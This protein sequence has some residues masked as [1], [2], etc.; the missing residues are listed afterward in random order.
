MER[1]TPLIKFGEWMPD[2]GSLNN[3]GATVAKNVVA[4]G[5]DYTA[6]ESLVSASDALPAEC[7]GMISGFDPTG[8]PFVFAG[9]A[10]KLYKLNGSAWTDVTRTSGGNYTTSGQNV[11]RFVQYGKYVFATNYNDAMQS[12]DL[13]SSTNFAAAAGSPPKAKYL[14][15]INNFV[16]ALNLDDSG[17]FPNRVEWSGLDDPTTWVSSITT[18]SDNQD[19]ADG[20]AAIALVG[21]QNSGILLMERAIYR[22]DY[23]GPSTIFNF[24]LA[25]INR[26]CSV[27]GSV[28]SYSNLV[29]F[30]GEDGF[31]MY[32]GATSRPIGY[33]KVDNWFRDNVD[34]SNI[35]KMQAAV[36]PRRK[37][38]LWSFPS[39]GGSG[40]NDRLL[41]YNWASDRWTYAEQG[42]ILAGIFTPATLSDSVS[43]ITDSVDAL[44]DGIAYSGGRAL[45]A[46]VNSDNRLCYFNGS[47]L[48]GELETREVRLNQGG[49]AYVWGVSPVVDGTVQVEIKSRDTQT[50]TFD[51]TG[52]QTVDTSTG[53]AFFGVDA[54]YHRCRV[55]ISGN[56]TRAQGVE[57]G[58]R[59]TGKV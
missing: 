42:G 9:T 24:T 14:S 10:T 43:F 23:V 5:E 32:D 29:F 27:A 54:R 34:F 51:A 56:W 4:I 44:A 48:T 17:T 1:T 36:N 49:R 12:F 50:A 35:Y 45:L 11:W 41:I 18:Q 55:V 31:S 19:I 47:S 25:E 53:E 3:P 37:Q 59:A 33:E 38:V 20:G 8:S 39:L 15:V 52:L 21:S 57:L 58:F 7:L 2:R 40:K 30:Y 13:S 22:M 26:G 46:C 16:V 6:I 28:V